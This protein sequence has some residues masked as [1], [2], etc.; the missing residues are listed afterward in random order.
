[1]VASTISYLSAAD[2]GTAFDALVASI[3]NA[4]RFDGNDQVPPAVVLWTDRDKQWLPLLP[5]LRVALPQ[6]VTLGDY[7][8]AVKSG[9]AIWLRP[10][11]GRR[12]P[13]ADWPPEAVPVLYLPGVS[14]HHLRAIE[15]CPKHLQP[16]AELQY[17]GTFWTQSN[18]NDWTVAAFLSSTKG[19]LR[20]GSLARCCNRD[21][22]PRCPWR[23]CRPTGVRAPRQASRRR[24]PE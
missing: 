22:A 5:R 18:T 14:R 16:I 3:R 19:G 12:V 1:V 13:E 10:L 17:R 15:T 21:R 23:A 11:L 9:P 2:T 24:F 20:P 7:D 8:P 4:A 6:L